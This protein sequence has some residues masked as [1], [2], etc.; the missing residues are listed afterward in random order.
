MTDP[1]IVIAKISVRSDSRDRWIEAGR[2]CV[3]E[4]RKE[5]GCISYDMFE[6][7]TEPNA[8]VFVESWKDKAALDAHAT[9]PHLQALLTVAAGCLANPPHI[10]AIM[11]GTRV[12]M[13]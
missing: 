9:T 4:T 7:V 6:S 5:S 12:R 10:E 3:E 1:V 2:T 13:M 8:F 11:D